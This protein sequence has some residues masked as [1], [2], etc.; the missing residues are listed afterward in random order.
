MLIEI[1]HRY[2][3]A[4]LASH[5]VEDNTIQKTLVAAV[6]Q[7]ANLQYADLQY[8]DLQNAYWQ[9][10]NLQGANLQYANLQGANLQ[11]ANLQY[12]NLQGAN[13]QYANLQYANL[14]NTNLQNAY[15]RGKNED[16]LE[17][18]PVYIDLHWLVT[19]TTKHLTIGCQ[20][21]SHEAWASFTED[22]IA[23]MDGYAQEFWSIW[24]TSLL[25]MC[26]AHKL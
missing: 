1:K 4:V 22:E 3:G 14:R 25:T 11:N 7:G 9:Y 2:S 6:K 24:K 17:K 20:H 8:A 12:A 15:L 16:S 5:A 21:H 23:S 13:L 19:I 26:A 18:A 10:A